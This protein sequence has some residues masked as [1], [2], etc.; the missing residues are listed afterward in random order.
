MKLGL[1]NKKRNISTFQRRCYMLE[2]KAGTS[3]TLHWGSVTVLS[4]CRLKTLMQGA[5]LTA[6]LV[7]SCEAMKSMR[8]ST[9]V[10]QV[11]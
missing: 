10:F 7:K 11:K 6:F 1:E 9:D 4:A 5:G 8:L 2:I 3:V